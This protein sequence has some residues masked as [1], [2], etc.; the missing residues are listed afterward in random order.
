MENST[1]KQLGK[2]MANMV[3]KNLRLFMDKICNKY[4]T[5]NIDRKII[6]EAARETLGIE[7][8]ETRREKLEKEYSPCNNY[9]FSKYTNG[10]GV[11][12][13]WICD[14]GH[15][16]PSEIKGRM[17]KGYG[18]SVCSN[19]KVADDKSNSLGVLRPEF[20]DQWSDENEMSIFDVTVGSGRMAKWI[21]EKGH[22]YSSMISDRTS[23][24][25]CSICAGKKIADD[26]SNSLGVLRPEF[27]NQWSNKNEFSI[28]DV[29]VSSG[30][31]A[32]WICENGHE[33]PSIINSRTGRG[34][35]CPVCNNKKIADDKSNSLGVLRPEFINQWSEEN[36]LTAFD[37]TVGSE[38]MINWICKNKHIYPATVKSRTKGSGCPHCS[39]K[40]ICEDGSNSLGVLRPEFINFWDSD[41]EKNIFQVSVGSGRMAKWICKKGHKYKMQIC[42]RTSKTDPRGC[43]ECNETKG[44]KFIKKYL[45]ENNIEFTTQYRISYNECP[46]LR[47]DF[48][49]P[50]SNT[51]IEFDGRQHFDEIA[52][53]GGEEGFLCRIRNDNYKNLYCQEND[54][55]L[56]RIHYLDINDTEHLSSLIAQI[57]I[58]NPKLILSKNYPK[59]W[60]YA[61]F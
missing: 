48:H 56:I 36:E 50:K 26:K 52:Y 55:S 29:T 60:L 37:L 34:D 4:R 30:K 32:I 44:E 28:F 13:K 51:C 6:R 27:I 24:H 20:I 18:C 46:N 43:P 19:R 45:T 12:A 8:G 11:K 23:G 15:K 16:W 59:D 9:P 21:C 35:G 7:I 41:N 2:A 1:S 17:K 53:Y 47:S 25:G 3:E 39:N 5:L 57:D 10:S 40:K 38:K 31:T 54:M 61:T 42:K 58:E 14:K 49:L 33:F 22:S